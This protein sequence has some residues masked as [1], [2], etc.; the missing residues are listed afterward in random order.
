MQVSDQSN[1]NVV[2]IHYERPQ[3]GRMK[4]D[5]LKPTNWK[6]R[7]QGHWLKVP[8]PQKYELMYKILCTLIYSP[9]V[10]QYAEKNINP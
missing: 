4:R 10:Q 5:M 3:A 9:Y 6:S 7:D 2:N 8:T 1:K